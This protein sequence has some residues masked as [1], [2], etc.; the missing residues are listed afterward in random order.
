MEL[1]PVNNCNSQGLGLG[2]LTARLIADKNE[3]RILGNRAGR[4]GTDAIEFPF[5]LSAG[6]LSIDASSS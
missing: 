6:T 3:I 2:Q 1:G 4:L 5:D